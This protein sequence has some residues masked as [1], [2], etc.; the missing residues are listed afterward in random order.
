MLEL[1]VLRL[2]A[3]FEFL[4]R[5]T[6]FNGGGTGHCANDARG[7][8]LLEPVQADLRV[9]FHLGRRNPIHSLYSGTG[10]KPRS[11]KHLRY[12]CHG[13]PDNFP[14]QNAPLPFSMKQDT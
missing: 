8:R 9:V 7:G 13:N 11:I 6:G 5:L 12:F 14:G 1:A 10:I 3:G 4:D 2:Q